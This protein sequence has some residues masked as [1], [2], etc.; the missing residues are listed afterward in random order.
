VT[1]WD[2]RATL[3][4]YGPTTIED[5][6]HDADTV[7]FL[8]DSGYNGREEESLRLSGVRAPETNQVG[9]TETR[10]YVVRWLS[11][12]YGE[13]RAVKLRR[14]WPFRILSEINTRVEPDQR[15]T[16]AR[17]LGWIYDI[18]TGECLNEAIATYISSHPEWPPG[19][20]A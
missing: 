2:R 8:I 9:F 14:R 18:E 10:L 15:T 6:V 19:K 20:E 13:T 11:A 17:Y 1:V 3:P 16:F 7:K 4:L 12:R 5:V